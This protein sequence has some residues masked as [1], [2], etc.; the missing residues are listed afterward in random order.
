MQCKLYNS[1]QK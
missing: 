1:N